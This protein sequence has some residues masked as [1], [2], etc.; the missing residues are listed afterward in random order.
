MVSK[1]NINYILVTPLF[2][3]NNYV[4]IGYWKSNYFSFNWNPLTLL[5]INFK[6]NI[7]I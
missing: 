3:I 2:K 4:H 1:E 7:D 5:Y 6:L